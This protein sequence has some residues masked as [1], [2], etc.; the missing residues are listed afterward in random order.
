M[1]VSLGSF[2]VVDA[3]RTV[4]HYPLWSD[5]WVLGCMTGTLQARPWLKTVRTVNEHKNTFRINDERNRR[6][7]IL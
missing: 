2:P 3:R 4:Y 7:I 1:S 5:F 6:V